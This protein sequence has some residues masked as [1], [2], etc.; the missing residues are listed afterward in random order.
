MITNHKSYFKELVNAL[1]FE[2][3]EELNKNTEYLKVRSIKERVDEGNAWYPIKIIDY[4]YGLGDTPFLEIERTQNL[5]VKHQFTSGSTIQ[6]FSNQEHNKGESCKAQIQYIQDDTMK[7]F[8]F[9]NDQPEWLDLGKLGIDLLV[10]ESSYKEMTKTLNLLIK[11]EVE[12]LPASYSFLHGTRNNEY[13]ENDIKLKTSLNESQAAAVKNIIN[14]D[15]LSLIYGPP[16]TG[17]TTTIVEA[18]Y[19]ISQ[20]EEY[21]I[22]VCAPSNAA[23][24]Y[25]VRKLSSIDLSV[26]RIGNI[27]RIDKTVYENTLEEKVKN[28]EDFKFIKKIKRNASELRKTALQYKRSFGPNERKQRKEVLQQAKEMMKD[29][30]LMEESI[31]DDVFIKSNVVCTTLVGSNHRYLRNNKF[32]VCFIDE[33]GQAIEP[34]AWIPICKSE[35]VIMAGDPQQLPPTVRSKAAKESGLAVSLFESLINKTGIANWLTVQ[36]RMNQAIMEFSN[37]QFY[38]GQLEADASVIDWNID[39]EAVTFIDTAGCGFEEEQNEKGK[40]LYNGGE[41]KVLQKHLK[42]INPKNSSI[43]VIS[44]YREQVRKLEK[45]HFKINDNN[46]IRIET[47]DSFQGQEADII[48]ISLVRSNGNSIIGF[49]KD[50]RRMNVALTRAKKKLVVIGDSATITKDPFYKAFLDYIESINAYK[51]AWE[52]IEY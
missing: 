14:C 8:L 37:Q 29:A 38:D 24:D 11:A 26:L 1:N 30:N 16:G 10:D 7:I 17:K 51:S 41:I 27:S 49:L 42:L 39:G 48:Y 3:E 13:Q 19:Q 50:Y 52:Y 4:G 40:S 21:P 31:I 43:A 32:K 12:D 34:A 2:R 36:Y 25:L 46:N 22:L 5:G 33:A 28:H 18:I 44:P 15:A 35:K 47:I 6:L 23:V 20:Q 45:S 9:Q